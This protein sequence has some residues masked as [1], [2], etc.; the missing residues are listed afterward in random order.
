MGRLLEERGVEDA[1]VQARIKRLF[2]VSRIDLTVIVLVVV[3]MVLK[4][5]S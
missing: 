3:A 1:E 2:M 4:P 5:G